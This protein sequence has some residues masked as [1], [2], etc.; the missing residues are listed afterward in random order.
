MD[1]L[2]RLMDVYGDGPGSVDAQVLQEYKEQVSRAMHHKGLAEDP[3][4]GDNTPQ[5]DSSS[6]RSS[7]HGRAL[8]MPVSRR[9]LSC[10]VWC[11][12]LCESHPVVCLS[13][14]IRN[15]VVG[16][17]QA[18]TCGFQDAYNVNKLQACCCLFGA[19]TTCQDR[20][21]W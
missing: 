4:T 13:A 16:T 21:A 14:L 9:F 10:P 2:D 15:W 1:Y 11:K 18:D 7:G 19:L 8:F 6:M 3:Q 20:C 17:W 12:G 5:A